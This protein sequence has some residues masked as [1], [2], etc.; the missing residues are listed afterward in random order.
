M[1]VSSHVKVGGCNGKYELF[2]KFPRIQK[3]A[4]QLCHAF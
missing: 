1:K 4:G 3:V 2:A